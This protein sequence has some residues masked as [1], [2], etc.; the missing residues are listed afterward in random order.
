MANQTKRQTSNARRLRREM[1]KSQRALWQVLRDRRTGYRFKRER[2]IGRY[3]LDFFCSDV[4]LCVE[5]DG[6]QHDLTQSK[7]AKRDAYLAERGIVTVR[8]SSIEC[9]ENA[10]TV[11]EMIRMKCDELAPGRG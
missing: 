11:G 4:L 3:V 1:S 5:V 7:D 6:D 10:R 8:I 9:F 2:P